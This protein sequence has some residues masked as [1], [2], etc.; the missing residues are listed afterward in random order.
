MK[1]TVNESP[2]EHYRVRRF[3]LYYYLEDDSIMVEEHKVK[4]M[5]MT[6][7]RALEFIVF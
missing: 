1:E 6:Q 2:A 4:N 5:G 3:D 7:G